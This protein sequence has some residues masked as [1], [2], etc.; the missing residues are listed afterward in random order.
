MTPELIPHAFVIDCD[1]VGCGCG[2][3]TALAVGT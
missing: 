3:P 2:L 1:S